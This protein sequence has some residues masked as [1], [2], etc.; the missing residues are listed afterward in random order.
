M[1]FWLVFISIFLVA[2][3]SNNEKQSIRE[4]QANIYYGKGTNQIALGKYTQALKSLLKAHELNPNRADI[5]NNL[6]MAYYFKN[7][8]QRA[9]SFIQES[10]RIDPKHTDA[11]LN[12]ATIYTE[13]GRFNEAQMQYN[14]VLDDLTYEYQHK[15][16]YNLGML[17]LKKNNFRKALNYFKQSLNESKNYCPAHFQIGELYYRNRSYKKALESYR[18]ASQGVC[19]NQPRPLYHQALSYI[20]LKQYD[21]AKVK[22]E[23]VIERFAL[24]KYQRMA[25]KKLQTVN[26]LI[27]KEMR[28][29]RN[30]EKPNGNILTPNF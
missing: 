24:T 2:C 4:K 23:E 30:F 11:R 1:R 20:Q 22:L 10:L 13:L 5:N 29:S 18:S 17:N 26:H 9:I 8:K 19:Y 27:Q 28:N 21:T 15:T 12:L 16:Y 3:A 14:I 6:G 7:R 25:N